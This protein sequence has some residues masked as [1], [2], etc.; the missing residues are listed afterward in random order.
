MEVTPLTEYINRCEL[1]VRTTKQIREESETDEVLFI[2]G[3][4]SIVIA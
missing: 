2:G 4:S 3:M 1:C